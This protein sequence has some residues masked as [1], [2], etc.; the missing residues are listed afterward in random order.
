MLRIPVLVSTT[1]LLLI[2]SGT[3]QGIAAA[4]AGCDREYLTEFIT[5]YLDAM[6]ENDPESLPVSDDVRFTEDCE[7]MELGEGLWE[8]IIDLDSYRLDILDIR[9]GGAFSFLVVREG[10]TWS[11]SV[12]ISPGKESHRPSAVYRPKENSR[13]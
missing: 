13:Q 10:S 2:V 3:L 12:G 9:Y 4:D 8:S 1:V 6:I 5:Q 7:E 11:F